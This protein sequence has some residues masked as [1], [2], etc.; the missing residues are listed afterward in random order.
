VCGTYDKGDEGQRYSNE[1]ER[2]Q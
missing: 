2:D 1:G